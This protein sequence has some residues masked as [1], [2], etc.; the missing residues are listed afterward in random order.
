MSENPHVSKQYNAESR[1]GTSRRRGARGKK[2][3]R[4]T[5]V[6]PAYVKRQI[7][8]YEFLGEEG[9][10]RL[11][12]QAEW[13][14]QEVGLEFRDDPRALEIWKQAGADVKG[15]RVRLDKGMA[16]EL[17]KTAPSEFT[18]YAR[19]PAKNVHIGG[20]SQVFAPVYGSL[21]A[22][23][24]WGATLWCLCRFREAGKNRPSVTQFASFRAGDRRTL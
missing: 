7:P 6:A 20:T 17:C 21:C 12:E 19:N 15:T 11:E 4:K 24:R 5:A 3:E 2:R 14:I 1:S 10:V 18:Q 16:R 8:F 13:L 22:G 9:L 23:S